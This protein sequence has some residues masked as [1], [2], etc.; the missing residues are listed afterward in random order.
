[1]LTPANALVSCQLAAQSSGARVASKAFAKPV[2]R[3][4]RLAG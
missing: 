1:V 2:A 4:D 3:T